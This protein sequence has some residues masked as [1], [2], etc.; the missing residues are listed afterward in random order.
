MRVNLVK[1][2]CTSCGRTANVLAVAESCGFMLC[3]GCVNKARIRRHLETRHGY[4]MPIAETVCMDC[5]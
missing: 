3:V 5:E 1:H 4:T 2:E